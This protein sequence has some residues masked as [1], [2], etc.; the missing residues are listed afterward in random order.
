MKE[1]WDVF[2]EDVARSHVAND[3]HN[4]APDPSFVVDAFLA[5]GLRP[6]LARESR[7][8]AIHDSTPRLAVEASNISPDRRVIQATIF[9]TRDQDCCRKGF[10]LHVADNTGT[11]HCELESKFE[12]TD[13]GTQSQDIHHRVPWSVCLAFIDTRQG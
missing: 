11:G 7:N 5:S 1:A 9:H 8:D 10:S 13:T 6:R 4:A 2:Q 3:S 12:S